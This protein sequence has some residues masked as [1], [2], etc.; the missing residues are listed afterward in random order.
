V[1]GRSPEVALA[2]SGILDR[3]YYSA[4]AGEVFPD[5]RSA[6]R[7]CVTVGMPEGLSPHPFLSIGYLP[8]PVQTAWTRG[9]VLKV[10]DH[11]L[12]QS[13]WGRPLGPLFHPDLYLE[14]AGLYPDRL[15]PGLNLGESPLAHFTAR[16]KAETPLPI[17]P[18]PDGTVPTFRG[19][20]QALLEHARIVAAQ[21]AD[22]PGREPSFHEAG[23]ASWPRG[24][25]P[26]PLHGAGGPLISIVARL[27]S[28]PA[29]QAAAILI[30]QGQTLHRW[31][32]IFVGD[33]DVPDPPALYDGRARVVRR[34]VDEPDPRVADWRNVGLAA[35]EGQYVGFLLPGRHWRPDFLRA[36]VSRLLDSGHSGG[37]AAVS[38]HDPTGRVTVMTGYG[39]L[40]TLRAGGW[41]E[42]G[43]LICRTEAALATGGF[44]PVLG[45]GADPEFA[46]QLATRAPLDSFPFVGS[47][48]MVA[49]LPRQQTSAA[50]ADGDWLAVIG[51]AWVD[52]AEVRAG[53]AARVPGR[54]SVVI[55]TYNDAAMTTEAVRSLLTTTSLPDLEITIVDNGSPLGFGQDLTA[56]FFGDSR[57][58]YRRLPLNLNFA[59]ACNVG[60]AASTGELV[61]FLNNDT[62]SDTDWLPG[63]VEHLTDPRVA[64][65]QPVLRYPDGTIQTAGTVFP[66]ANGL[67]CHFLTGRPYLDALPTAQM[68]FHATTAAALVMRAVDFAELEGFDPHFVN[69]MEDVDLCLRA[70]ELR[71]GG[72]R[73]D[74]RSSVT[75]LE[76]KTP[77]RGRRIP[78][79]RRFFMERWSG[80]LPGP[81]TDKFERAGFT[82]VRVE[83][84]GLEIPSP[85]PVIAER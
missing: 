79:N 84:D 75:H 73:V 85:R 21:N 57:V 64:G 37:H 27:E 47:D 44:D 45:P 46:I 1:P 41:I 83:D 52:W 69:G 2:R 72:F 62:R 23:L 14:Q 43:S 56:H 16:A 58:H 34:P 3:G 80:R 74:P 7:H 26:L 63:V 32:L 36:A 31:E 15:T 24:R 68:W 49:T 30:L 4:A 71:P 33:A 65:A 22:L 59:I 17:P 19:A 70:L 66:W 50:G 67:P 53:T 20:R 42:L 8:R 6:A 39:D 40:Q 76:G 77:G 18:R 12:D 29:A 11:L 9:R 48:R 35:A 5:R 13:G 81:E 78:E 82:L 38:L 51:K 25:R 54:V 61:V 28:S 55:P 10:L 60:Y